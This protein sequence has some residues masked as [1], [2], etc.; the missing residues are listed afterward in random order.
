MTWNTSDTSDIDILNSRNS[1]VIP[2]VRRQ[3]ND[4]YEKFEVRSTAGSLLQEFVLS[5][6]TYN[7]YDSA[8]YG[9][10]KSFMTFYS[11]GDNTI[12]YQLINYDA[13]TDTL[14]TA[15]HARGDNY[16]SFDFYYS[17][18]G[19]LN[20]VNSEI[21]YTQFF[22]Y[23]GQWCG[24]TRTVDYCDFVAMYSGDNAFTTH[25]FNNSGSY[26]K[27]IQLYGGEGFSDIGMSIPCIT[28]TTG[29]YYALYNMRKSG[30]SYTNIMLYSSIDNNN[31]WEYVM[32]EYAGYA[33]FTTYATTGTFY[34]YNKFGVLVASQAFNGTDFD[35]WQNGSSLYFTDFVNGWVF[36]ESTLTFTNIG[37]YNDSWTPNYYRNS[38][39]L[40]PSILFIFND[41]T[42]E[43]VMITPSGISSVT[44]FNSSSNYWGFEAGSGSLMYYYRTNG[45]TTLTMEYYDENLV[46]IHSY[47]S[48]MINMYNRDSA[49]NAV[50][51]LLSDGSDEIHQPYFISG[52]GFT[53]SNSNYID[54]D[55]SF[56]DYYWW[57]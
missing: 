15:T 32:G 46:L 41:N 49:E 24:D 7:N 21:I 43:G 39:N 16:D 29:G 42:F 51:A 12:Q 18:V 13:E 30:T 27:A 22:N 19:G 14:V 37:L 44:T 6:D 48:N 11:S 36:N 50:W 25:V 54:W 52:K 26:N 23:G 45:D 57:D 5:A 40:R 33:V 1:N 8:V 17:N 9:T 35:V 38:G 2:L 28:N 56:N 53:I 31:I 3:N 55:Y 20:D 10:N 47:T 34:V 4:N